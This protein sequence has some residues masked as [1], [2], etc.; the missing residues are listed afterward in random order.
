M[1]DHLLVVYCPHGSGIGMNLVLFERGELAANFPCGPDRVSVPGLLSRRDRR[2][3]HLLKVLRK[4]Q[5]DG[6]DAGI[7]DGKL[8]TGI[9]TKIDTD[10][11]H[12]SLDLDTEPP[13]RIPIRLAVGFSRPIQLRRL[14]RDCASLGLTAI[15]LIGTELGEK[16]YRDTKLLG[17]GGARRALI[18]GAS[19]ARDTRLPCLAVHSDLAAWL[20]ARPWETSAGTAAGAGAAA[21]TAAAVYTAG[22]LLTA[23]DNVQPAGSFSGLGKAGAAGAVLAVGSERGWSGRE[24][25]L[26]DRT[27]FSRLSLGSRA[28]RTE[29][30]CVAAAVLLMEKIGCL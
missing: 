20:K 8:G 2:A 5:G 22:A 19:Q 16:S 24:R 12:F 25:E 1:P 15:D 28:L 13:E 17:D 10:G 4:K 9:I 7:V 11:V 29:T 18:E 26:L 6:F 27:G 3:E 30:A 21:G 23:A 14:F